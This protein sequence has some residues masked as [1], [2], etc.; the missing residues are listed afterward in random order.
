[1]E[2]FNLKHGDFVKMK[3][4]DIV[5]IDNENHFRP[6]E[7]KYAGDVINRKVGD[8]VFF[9]DEDIEFVIE[10]GSAKYKEL[11]MMIEEFEKEPPDLNDLFPKE[12][13]EEEELPPLI[14]ISLE[15]YKEL[16]E[17]KGRYEE[18]RKFESPIVLYDFGKDN[19]TTILPQREVRTTD[20]LVAPP[21]KIT[22]NKE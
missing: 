7:S 19:Q 14:E 10:D 12:E 2:A 6:P 4:G 16:L 13:K 8:L 5:R 22:C 21:Y 11:M 17:I 15:E 1:M 9:G 18:L 20:P 3:N